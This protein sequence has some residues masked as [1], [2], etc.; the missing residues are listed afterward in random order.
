M[1]RKLRRKFYQNLIY[2]IYGSIAFLSIYILSTYITLP[3]VPRH[4]LLAEG[5][6][7]VINSNI[8]SN[9]VMFTFYFGIALLIISFILRLV[10]SKFD[11]GFLFTKGLETFIGVK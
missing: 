11:F 4:S 1:L 7:D 2:T 5:F 8:D 10:F 6:I 9:S 3:L